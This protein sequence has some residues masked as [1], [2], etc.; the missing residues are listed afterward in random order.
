MFTLS[1]N[2][3][4]FFVFCSFGAARCRKWLVATGSVNSRAALLIN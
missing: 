4:E 2:S 3:N 1:V